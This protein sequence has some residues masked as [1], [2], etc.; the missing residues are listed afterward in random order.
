MCGDDERPTLVVLGGSSGLSVSLFVPFLDV[1]LAFAFASALG[2]GADE[3][4]VPE[5]SPVSDGG[6]FTAL[7]GN[8]GVGGNACRRG[9][10]PNTS[11][12]ALSFCGV[13]VGVVVCLPFAVIRRFAS[14]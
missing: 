9:G 10:S 12:A 14:R 2:A 5:G 1:D 7:S 4:L 6:S 3:L 13:A 8:A 11:F